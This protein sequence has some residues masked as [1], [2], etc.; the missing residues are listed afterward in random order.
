MTTHPVNYKALE[1]FGNSGS[2]MRFEIL[3]QADSQEEN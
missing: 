1:Y 3:E 2:K